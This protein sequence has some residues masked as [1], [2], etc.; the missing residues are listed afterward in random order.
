[1][2]SCTFQVQGQELVLEAIPDGY[3][4]RCAAWTFQMLHDGRMRLWPGAQFTWDLTQALTE[5][6]ISHA[7][8]KIVYETWLEER[9]PAV[10]DGLLALGFLKHER[11]G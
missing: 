6:T 7:S 3:L 10:L 2:K 9:L 8:A 5:G 4:V 1:M 11:P